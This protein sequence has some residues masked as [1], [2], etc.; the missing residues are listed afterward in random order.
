MVFGN[1]EHLFLLLDFRMIFAFRKVGRRCYS[2]NQTITGLL[3]E[4]TALDL[5]PFFNTTFRN[6]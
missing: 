5:L 2:D 6:N 4:F 3:L 1:P